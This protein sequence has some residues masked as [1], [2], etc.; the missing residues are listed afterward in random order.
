MALQSQNLVMV[1]LGIEGDQPSSDI[2]PP[3]QPPLKDGIHLRWAFKPEQG[4]PWYG[5]YLFRRPHEPNDE[6]HDGIKQIQDELKEVTDTAKELTTSLGWFRSDENLHLHLHLTGI[7]GKYMFGLNGRSYLRLDLS[8]DKIT[9]WVEVSILFL[10]EASIKV[11]ALLGEKPVIWKYASGKENDVK[12]IVLEFDTITSMLIGPGPALL[13]G[14]SFITASANPKYAKIGWKPVP[15]FP[16]P[17]R[18]PL[19][20]PE[21]P[22]TA[23]EREDLEKAREE[24][25]RRILYGQPDSYFASSSQDTFV[26][27]HDQLVHLVK[28]GPTSVPMVDRTLPL[29]VYNTGKISVNNDSRNVTGHGTNWN[30]NLVGLS[31]Q[32]VGDSDGTIKIEH[33]DRRIVTGAKTNWSNDLTGLTFKVGGERTE[34]IIIKVFPP[35]RLKL[36][37]PYRGEPVSNKSYTITDKM[38][39]TISSV[40]SSN[41]LTLESAY[42]GSRNHLKHY[43]YKIISKLSP[44]ERGRNKPQ[45]PDY[46]PLDMVLLGALNPAVAQMLGLYWVDQ[47]ADHNVA[48]DYLI[49]ADHK[50]VLG[51]DSTLALTYLKKK[52]PFRDVDGYIVFNQEIK[53][54]TPL[55]EPT[56][57]RVYALPG[58]FNAAQEKESLDAPNIAGLRWDL[59]LSKEG[60]LLTGMPIMYHLWRAHYE[61]SGPSEIEYRLITKKQKTEKQSALVP[62]LVTKPRLPKG[63]A[64]HRPPAW[65]PFQMHAIDRGLKD[66]RYS[67]KIMGIDI[68]GRHSGLSKNAQWYQWKPVPEPRPWYYSDSRGEGVVDR[69][70]AHF[71][72]ELLDKTP[73]PPPAG[74]EAHV[75]DPRDPTILQDEAYVEWRKKVGPDM[76]G[77][78]VRWLWTPAHMLQAPD[79]REFRIYYHPGRMNALL[80]QTVSVLNVSNVESKVKT[81][82]PNILPSN[83]YVSAKLQIG[84]GAENFTIVASD[85][86]TPLKVQVKS[87]PIYSTGTVEVD[88]GSHTV[89]GSGTNWGKELTGLTF[90]IKG[91]QTTY[92]ILKISKPPTQQLELDRPYMGNKGTGKA[93]TIKEKQPRANVPCTIVIPPVYKTGTIK[94]ARDSTEIEGKETGWK[95]ELVGR[96]LKISGESSEYTI[97]GVV[98]ET[99]LTID[100]GYEGVNGNYKTYSIRHPLFVDYTVTTKWQ[101]RIYVVGY[102]EHV[103]E[104]VRPAQ[105]G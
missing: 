68:F 59:G 67:Y 49:L 84:A 76:I 77:L 17:M 66:G 64:P 46:Y 15:D 52:E 27:L 43:K 47:K 18:M 97:K 91:E 90:Q 94:V 33:G 34:Y 98:S 8:L 101:E 78:R 102:N 25:S 26:Q 75:L 57:P 29:P 103:T 79:T 2:Q 37:V 6:T 22:C 38:T 63:K 85:A 48:Y 60:E 96:I 36:D 5:Y 55:A 53:K 83:A 41:Q 100:K 89:H 50:G 30:T 87:G 11:T 65:P 13:K 95:K 16:Y 44:T 23:G 92:T 28:G 56:N 93:Y 35:T 4:F 82:I 3:L 9:N 54:A 24:A 45:I 20:H 81:D 42:V 104:T 99:Q 14:L 105:G 74:I 73:P 1:A 72:V 21:Y 7:T 71:S 32:L 12:R 39:Y 69:P 61:V 86:G 58:R 10:R 62:I 80:G 40:D 19:T 88:E 31:L 51:K 70:N